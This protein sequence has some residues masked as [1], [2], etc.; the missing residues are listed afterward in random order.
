M[1][2]AVV[3]TVVLAL[4]AACADDD[5]G[6]L[7]D[8]GVTREQVA[9]VPATARRDLDLLFV[10]DDSPGGLELQTSLKAAFPAFLGELTLREQLPNLHIG[11]AST[12]I[13]AQGAEDT[14]PG[15]SIG[16]GP[17]SCSGVGKAGA[18]QTNST[19]LLNGTFI[20][21]MLASDGS[22][23]T[24]YTG[25]LTNVFNAIISLGAS[26]CGFEQP[27]EAMRRALDNNPANA[28]FQRPATPL[29]VITLT[30]E[31]D[32]SFAHSTLLGGATTVLGPL[33]SFRC[34][35]FGVLCDT[36]GA[37][38]DE[39][40]VLGS[41]TRCHWNNDSAYLTRRDRYE[42]FI[43]AVN[44]DARNVFYGAIAGGPVSELV[45]EART[46]PGGGSAVPAL[47]HVCLY[48]GMY[49]PQAADPAVRIQELTEVVPRGRFEPVCDVDLTVSSVAMARE[50]R[51]LLGDPC[52]TRD[53]A[54][55]AD[56]VV[57]D[58]TLSGETPIPPCS[59]Q[60]T[61]DC[62]QLVDDATCTTVSHLRVDVTRSSPASAD[63]MVSVRCRI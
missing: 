28:G 48:T 59:T 11:V 15:A 5:S 25:T 17:G 61:T 38:T 13:G 34:T 47:Q 41:K 2:F 3:L 52:L 8:A 19:T 53:I 43:A 14:Q 12:D 4:F 36:G 56:C 20:V 32:C 30:D 21:D 27:I 37:T 49:G 54:S 16:S 33:Q 29:A 42:Q 63:T 23:T 6:S 35:R 31:D 55:P 58:Q 50:I 46:P 57:A 39:M 9:L 18:L 10:T 7:A 40:Y 51:G 1:R 62:Y 60:R 44:G 45:V 26:G 24:N 22:R